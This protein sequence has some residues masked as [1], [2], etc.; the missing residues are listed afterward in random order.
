MRAVAQA[1]PDDAAVRHQLA[2]GQ[3]NTLIDA[4]AED[5]LARPDALLDELRGLDQASPDDAAGSRS[6]RQSHATQGIAQCI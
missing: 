4:K 1:F 6:F 3:F 5:D 2:N